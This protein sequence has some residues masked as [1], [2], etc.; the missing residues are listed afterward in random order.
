MQHI[1]S[2]A[3]LLPEIIITWDIKYDAK[4]G[5]WPITTLKVGQGQ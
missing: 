5:Q 1:K 3:L 2:L 4:S